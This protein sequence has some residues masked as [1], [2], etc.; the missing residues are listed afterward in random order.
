VFVWENHLGKSAACASH[1]AVEMENTIR[2]PNKYAHTWYVP[3]TDEKRRGGS[4][5]EVKHYFRVM[6]KFGW[7][8]P[9]LW[10]S[11][12]RNGM[13]RMEWFSTE[14]QSVGRHR[15][16][17]NSPDTRLGSSSPRFCFPLIVS[18]AFYWSIAEKRAW[19]QLRRPSN[20]FGH[21]KVPVEW[22]P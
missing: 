8:L 20:G 22:N 12:L 6:Q 3:L 11:W 5:K 4:R 2:W 17:Q 13:D 18:V 15:D 7:E 1:I 14:C 16:L 10:G 19:L 21:G 9:W